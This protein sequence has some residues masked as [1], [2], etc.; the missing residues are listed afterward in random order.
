[1]VVVSVLP[2]ASRS[3][4]KPGRALGGVLAHPAVSTAAARA[5]SRDR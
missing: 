5:A 1:M 3:A 2:S 4:L